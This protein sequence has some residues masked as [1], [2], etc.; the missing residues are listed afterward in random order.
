[1]QRELNQ[2][3]I[4]IIPKTF[5]VC[6]F[7]QFRPISLCN[8]CYKIISKIIVNRL[9]PLL[10][11]LIDPAQVAFIPNR[12]ITENVVAAQEVVHNF[13]QS[14]K[15]R[16]YMGV[17]LDFQKAYDKMEWGFLLTVL[18]AFGFNEKFVRLIHQCISFVQYTPL[19]NGSKCSSFSPY[20]GLRQGD[21]LS[22]YLFILGSEVLARLINREVD[23]GLISG[24]KV[25][26]NAPPISKLFYADDVLLFCKAKTQEINTLIKCV[27][28]YCN[29]SKQTIS[30][31]KS[32]FFC[33]KG[34]S[35]SIPKVD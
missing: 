19:L 32:G 35:F 5:G 9:R 33:I 10:N 3:F 20:R 15:R 14:K 16:G 24:V 7:N 8:I 22:P 12:W 23:Q 30:L 18:K 26:R 21:P 1:M 34:G 31:E 6:N 2:T 28:T 27:A 11:R 29:W 25:T 13:T 17:K 4:T